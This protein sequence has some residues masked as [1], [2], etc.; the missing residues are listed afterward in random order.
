MPLLF[1][2]TTT[3]AWQSGAADPY[4]GDTLHSEGFIHCSLQHQV[5]RVVNARFKGRQD[6][7]LLTIYSKKVEEILKM[8][9]GEKDE[10]FPHLYGPL[11]R[12]AV[13]N[14]Q[15]FKPDADGMFRKLPETIL[16]PRP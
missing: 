11:Q 3:S 16:E 4:C 1:H 2:I 5:L 6:L 10:L 9:E 15:V 13:A 12:S 7:L 14:V 8:E